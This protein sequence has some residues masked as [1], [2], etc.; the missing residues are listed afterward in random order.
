MLLDSLVAAGDG[1]RDSQD[2]DGH[3]FIRDML[4]RKQGSIT[5]PWTNPGESQAREKLVERVSEAQVEGVPRWFINLVPIV[6]QP[7]QAQIDDGGLQVFHLADLLGL[8]T[9]GHHL[10]HV[11]G[12]LQQRLQALGQCG[13]VFGQQ[14]AHQSSSSVFNSLPLRAS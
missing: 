9:I 3:F 10:D 6:V 8:A 7:G 5:Y 13:I 11:T 12:L 1:L 2:S 14:D 4:D